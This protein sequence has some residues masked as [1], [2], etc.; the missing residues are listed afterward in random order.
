M[1]PCVQDDAC[2]RVTC[3]LLHVLREKVHSWSGI[4]L[5][6]PDLL[7]SV[8][9]WFSI[10]WSLRLRW[11]LSL[12]WSASLHLWRGFSNKILTYAS[13]LTLQNKWFN[14][15][16]P[17][18]V[19]LNH[20]RQCFPKTVINTE[21]QCPKHQAHQI[22]TVYGLNILLS[23]SVNLW[24]VSVPDE[25]ATLPSLSSFLEKEDYSL[26][27]LP[28]VQYV[29]LR[30]SLSGAFLRHN[31]HIPWPSCTRTYARILNGGFY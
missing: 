23:H 27:M 15:N 19:V 30:T 18:N 4:Y 16:Y 10:Q 31:W 3:Q 9:H 24:L 6:F 13:T 12:R 2:I 7:G 28:V 22:Q 26:I 14:N 1:G 8:N 20:P 25:V 29:R 21:L 11:L 17:I 5:Y